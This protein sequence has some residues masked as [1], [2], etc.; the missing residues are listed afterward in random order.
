MAKKNSE[1][2]GIYYIVFQYQFNNWVKCFLDGSENYELLY[3][4]DF[5]AFTKELPNKGNIESQIREALSESSFFLWDVDGGYVRRLSGS[6][7]EKENVLANLK[8][9]K[10]EKNVFDSRNPV[11]FEKKKGV[12]SFTNIFRNFKKQAL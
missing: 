11:N 7:F 8:A 9:L 3:I 12:L 6:S 5:I 4:D 1:Q 10:E 2:L